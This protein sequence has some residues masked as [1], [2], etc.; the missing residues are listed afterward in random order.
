PIHTKTFFTGLER[1]VRDHVYRSR[2]LKIMKNA[3]L[4]LYSRVGES[5]EDFLARCRD[6]AEDLADEETAKLRDR[7]EGKMDTLRDRI[8]RY[9]LDVDEKELDIETRR[10]EEMASGA[11][12][13]IGILLGGR[14]RTSDLSK[15]ASKRSQVRKAVQRL[16]TSERKLAAEMRELVEMEDEL[17]EDILE[18]DGAWREKAEDVEVVEIGLEKMDITVDEVALVWIPR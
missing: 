2:E 13:L 17:G 8:E 4:R 1:D 6:V 15:A 5:P 9:R 14:K 18:I 7:F 3:S 11:G 16:E 10:Q 12:S